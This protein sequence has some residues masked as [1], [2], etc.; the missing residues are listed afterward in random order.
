M[1][2]VVLAQVTLPSNL[3]CYWGP[4]VA[5][6]QALHVACGACSCRG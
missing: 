3:I 1:Q 2:L 5:A 4:S 6:V